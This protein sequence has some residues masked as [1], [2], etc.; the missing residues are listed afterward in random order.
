M[1]A[2][3]ATTD[4]TAPL[5]LIG[6]AAAVIWVSRQVRANKHAPP[7]PAPQRGVRHTNCDTGHDLNGADDWFYPR[8]ARSTAIAATRIPNPKRNVKR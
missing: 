3:L 7:P 8:A 6:L 1:I 5:A 4:F 2:W